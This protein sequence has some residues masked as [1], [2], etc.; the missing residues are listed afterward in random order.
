MEPESGSD[1][2]W[3]RRIVPTWQKEGV[4]AM[5]TQ[6]LPCSP[7]IPP[8]TVTSRSGR[9]YI[10]RPA[11]PEDRGDLEAFFA[12]LSHRSR[13]LRYRSPG[14]A[15]LPDTEAERL[16]R[17]GDHLRVVLIAVR[18]RGR[19]IWA[20]GELVLK[21]TESDSAEGALCVRDECQR[22]GL[23]SAV[24]LRIAQVAMRL[25]VHT[26]RVDV[27]AEN[28]GMRRI[29]RKAGI[30]SRAEVCGGEIGF[31]LDLRAPSAP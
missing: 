29:I 17:A 7:L 27:S 8:T 10:I 13:W 3:R 19:A 2:P 14:G 22:D 28:A 30:P 23:G 21:K 16:T 1:G 15:D 24:G 6:E 9:R 18:P 12:S 11:L 26:L 4:S 20:V 31:F 25:G 5:K